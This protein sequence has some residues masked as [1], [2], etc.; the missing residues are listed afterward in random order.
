MVVLTEVS[1][2]D[3]SRGF[4]LMESSVDGGL[5]VRGLVERCRNSVA[6]NAGVPWPDSLSALASS[7]VL[8]RY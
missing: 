3:G 7:A 6:L 5:D 2:S 1:N 4:L 8:V